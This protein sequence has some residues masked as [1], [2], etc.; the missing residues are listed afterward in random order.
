MKKSA[1]KLEQLKSALEGHTT[2]LIILQDN[3]DPDAIAAAAALRRLANS[4]FNIQCSIAHGGRVGRGE[5]RAMVK[6]LGLNLRPM[7][8]IDIVQFELIALVDTQPGAGNNS[9]P[10]GI[11][12]DIVIDHHRCRPQTRVCRFTDIRSRY[13]ATATIM[14]E[15]L[16]SAKIKPDV[17]LATALLY[18]IRSDTQD[19]GRDTTRAD[20]A[21]LTRLMPI[22]NKRMLSQIQR[23][24]VDRD[25]FQMLENALKNA[26]VYSNAIVT[27]LGIIENPDMIAETADLLLR[28]DLT[29]WVM[30]YGFVNDKML[31]SL[32]TEQDEL[33]ADKVIHRM[34]ARK[35]TGGGHP[36]YA[37]GQIPLGALS[38]VQKTRLVRKVIDRFLQQVTNE[39]SKPQPLLPR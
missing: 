19:L 11:E 20:I 37:G 35:G 28:D 33:G 16:Q 15:Y 36:S 39:L 23:G 30:V 26:Y 24:K 29:N 32:R 10:Q 5:N 38:E 25:Y 14:T 18:A 21:A 2:L 27:T 13:G 34:V 4:L 17:P 7:R 12:P 6:Y 1:A 3:P 8:Q 31:I 22:A 9:L